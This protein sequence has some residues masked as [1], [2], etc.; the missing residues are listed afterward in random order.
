MTPFP[1]K[2]TFSRAGGQAFSTFLEGT[3]FHLQHVPLT[4]WTTAAAPPWPV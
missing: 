2:S 4:L 1:D 3:Q